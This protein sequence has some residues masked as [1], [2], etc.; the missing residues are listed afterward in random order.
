MRCAGGSL[1]QHVARCGWGAGAV[2]PVWRGALPAAGRRPLRTD[3]AWHVAGGG[4]LHIDR[5]TL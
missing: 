5:L 2:A 3:L 1:D 4:P